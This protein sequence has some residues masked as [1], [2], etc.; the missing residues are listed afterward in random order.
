MQLQNPNI[1]FLKISPDA[2]RAI[3]TYVNEPREDARFI[4]IDIKNGRRLGVHGRDSNSICLL[5]ANIEF[6]PDGL[7]LIARAAH[8]G[9]N[10][11]NEYPLPEERIH[12][13]ATWGYNNG[14]FECMEYFP[15]AFKDQ[16]DKLI[17]EL[18]NPERRLYYCGVTEETLPSIDDCLQQID[19]ETVTHFKNLLRNDVRHMVLHLQ[20]LYQKI[21]YKH[22]YEVLREKDLLP[23]PIP[24]DYGVK[25]FSSEIECDAAILREAIEKTRRQLKANPQSIFE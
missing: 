10:L 2:A 22:L 18:P 17:E 6:T 1:H 21:I 3:L 23:N 4:L 5:P 16:Y 9:L 19:K 8:G 13:A 11:Y 14:G 24:D 20:P 12:A 7:G 15:R 25:I